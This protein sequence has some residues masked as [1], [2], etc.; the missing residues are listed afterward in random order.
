ML[1]G[2]AARFRHDYRVSHPAAAENPEPITPC[3]CPGTERLTT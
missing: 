1:T 3:D 2:T